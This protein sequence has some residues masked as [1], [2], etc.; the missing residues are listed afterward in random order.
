MNKSFTLIDIMKEIF[1][2][3][4][5]LFAITFTCIVISIIF[6]NHLKNKQENYDIYFKIN[7]DYTGQSIPNND[8]IRLSESLFTSFGLNEIVDGFEYVRENGEPFISI[9]TLSPLKQD[10][11]N[12]LISELS[13][14]IAAHKLEYL[15]YQHLLKSVIKDE[16]LLF[17][18]S[19][20]SE[21]FFQISKL[22]DIIENTSYSFSL[23]DKETIGIKLPIFFVLTVGLLIGLIL[24][25]LI[26]Y[27]YIFVVMSKNFLSKSK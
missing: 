3:K 8:L 26:L 17:N 9:K 11:T 16:P 6:S 19:K 25:F 15:N 23:Y 21:E 22:I 24:S 20:I 27:F 18:S 13:N 4:K 12:E 2:Y 14:K 1:L 10:K 5:S 7:Y